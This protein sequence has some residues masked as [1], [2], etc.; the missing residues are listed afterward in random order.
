MFSQ[1][2]QLLS[3]KLFKTRQREEKENKLAKLRKCNLS[4]TSE[5][6]DS[7]LKSMSLIDLESLEYYPTF[8]KYISLINQ[9]SHIPNSVQSFPNVSFVKKSVSFQRLKEKK[10]C[11]SRLQM[12]IT[13]RRKDK[14]KICKKRFMNTKIWHV[15]HSKFSQQMLRIFQSYEI[16]KKELMQDIDSCAKDIRLKGHWKDN[17]PDLILD[18]FCIDP[19][20]IE[21]VLQRKL[22]S[23]VLARSLE[24]GKNF[25]KFSKFQS[26][27]KN[28]ILS[29]LYS[30]NNK[31]RSIFTKKHCPLSKYTKCIIESSGDWRKYA[32][33]LIKLNNEKTEN[34]L[35]NVIEIIQANGFII[36]EKMLGK[37]C[38]EVVSSVSLLIEFDCEGLSN[39]AIKSMNASSTQMIPSTELWSLLDSKSGCISKFFQNKLKR[40]NFLSYNKLTRGESRMKFLDISNS[41]KIVVRDEVRRKDKILRRLVLCYALVFNRNKFEC[42]FKRCMTLDL[43]RQIVRLVCG[44]IF[45]NL[46][47]DNVVRLLKKDLQHQ[48]R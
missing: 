40:K 41:L 10:S 14:S 46:S 47:D 18:E 26:E 25:T 32:K 45:L 16:N 43:K 27:V 29:I 1:L 17:I 3:S 13:H 11:P 12:M 23:F 39:R 33:E 8:P 4:M 38:S 22:S 48:A 24:I 15:K 34:F 36:S 2:G 20:K 19:R 35:K 7:L 9:T 30:M 42:Y 44:S 21:D 28:E 5:W 31:P 37:L 6:Y